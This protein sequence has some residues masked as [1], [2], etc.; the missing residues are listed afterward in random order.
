MLGEEI[1]VQ[2]ECKLRDKCLVVLW[3]YARYQG[4]HLL[5]GGEAVSQSCLTLRSNSNF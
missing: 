1:R 3:R 2:A 4:R 5:E